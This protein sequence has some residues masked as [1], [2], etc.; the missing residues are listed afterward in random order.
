MIFTSLGAVTLKLPCL[1]IHSTQVTSASR[2]WTISENQ[3]FRE[4]KSFFFFAIKKNVTNAPHVS[5]GHRSHYPD[6]EL[7][8]VKFPVDFNMQNPP[9]MLSRI[10]PIGA[11]SVERIN[12]QQTKTSSD[13]DTRGRV[14]IYC[15]RNPCFINSVITC[16]AERVNFIT[17]FLSPA[18]DLC[19]A[20]VP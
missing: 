4:R 17:H 3:A 12:D 9:R 10:D 7:F 6:N 18:Q 15:V 2:Q 5:F 14:R 13:D 11:V 16:S 20:P 1:Y 8:H 19:T